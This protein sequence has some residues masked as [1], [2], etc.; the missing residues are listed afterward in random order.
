MPPARPSK[1]TH[2]TKDLTLTQRL[3]DIAMN[4]YWVWQPETQDLFR[5]L[6]PELWE[7]TNHNPVAFL[8]QMPEEQVERRGG[9]AY[10]NTRIL[11]A[12]R[13][14]SEYMAAPGQLGGI[15]PAR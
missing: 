3:W 4:L 9:E 6:E 15:R 8:K 2:A 12:H 10:L 1:G 14:L 11:F 13:R 7:A 5:E